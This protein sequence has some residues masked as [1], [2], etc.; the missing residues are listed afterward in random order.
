MVNQYTQQIKE[1][2]Y[3]TFHGRAAQGGLTG[4]AVALVT[5]RPTLPVLS[6][7]VMQLVIQNIAMTRACAR[8]FRLVRQVST[9][10]TLPQRFRVKP[11]LTFSV[12]LARLGDTALSP[13]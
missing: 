9:W 1:L 6:V 4:T 5:L 7:V 13:D 12:N 3:S 8:M 10:R 11:N 2:A